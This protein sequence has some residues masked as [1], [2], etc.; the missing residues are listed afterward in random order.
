MRSA[1]VPNETLALMKRASAAVHVIGSDSEAATRFDSAGKLC[2]A[3]YH[4]RL[5]AS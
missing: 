3:L 5:G 4:K 1:S 2:F